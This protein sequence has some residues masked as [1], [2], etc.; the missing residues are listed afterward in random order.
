MDMHATDLVGIDGITRVLLVYTCQQGVYHRGHV[1]P[2]PLP[3]ISILHRN[4][5]VG[6]VCG[7]SEVATGF[8]LNLEAKKALQKCTN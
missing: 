7:M 8:S 1:Q 2:L 6:N 5:P 3:L 4:K